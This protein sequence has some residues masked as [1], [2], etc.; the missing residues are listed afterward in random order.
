MGI[1]SLPIFWVVLLIR[2]MLSC[3]TVERLTILFAFRTFKRVLHLPQSWQM[4][5]GTRYGGCLK[6]EY[7]KIEYP[8]F[9]GLYHI[10][11]MVM[12]IT[13]TGA[14]RKWPRNPPRPLRWPLGGQ[15]PNPLPVPGAADAKGGNAMGISWEAAPCRCG[16]PPKYWE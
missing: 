2:T 6:I 15:S 3:G 8:M 1:C 16:F 7:L 5:K 13:I 12:K 9:N 11:V 14:P 10:F 4:H